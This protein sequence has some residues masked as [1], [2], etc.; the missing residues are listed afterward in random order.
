M[1]EALNDYVLIRPDTINGN[2]NLPG[3]A[4]NKPFHKGTIISVG[5]QTPEDVRKG[6]VVHYKTSS[7]HIEVD[8]GEE[9]F[10]YVKLSELLGKIS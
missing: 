5:S 3:R 2:P 6:V 8:D 4:N 7:Y 10:I 9:K 1:I